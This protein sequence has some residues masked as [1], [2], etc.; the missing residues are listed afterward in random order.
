MASTD[1]LQGK[2]ADLQRRASAL[3]GQHQV[4]FGDLFTPKFM[5][6]FTSCSSIDELFERGGIA[7][8]SQEGFECL[9]ED[10]LDQLVATYTR[11]TT[12]EEMKR[13]AGEVW[14]KRQL[15]F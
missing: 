5:A 6:K 9:P 1:D 7:V 4:P 10:Q 12:W 8:D 11:F 15:G 3:E 14:V 13:A 2:L